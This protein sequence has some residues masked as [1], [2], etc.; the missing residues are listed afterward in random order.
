MNDPYIGQSAV[1]KP[2]IMNM[3][4]LNI[5]PAKKPRVDKIGRNGTWNLSKYTQ[6]AIQIIKMELK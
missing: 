3:L 4:D 1:L 2:T 5:K 6:M